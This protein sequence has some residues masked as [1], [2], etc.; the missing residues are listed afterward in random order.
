M[1][2]WAVR[3]AFIAQIL[4]YLSNDFLLQ[5][6]LAI[7]HKKVLVWHNTLIVYGSYSIDMVTGGVI[8]VTAAIYH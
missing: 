3:L 8:G 7:V 1:F 6:I 4:S 5:R 2:L